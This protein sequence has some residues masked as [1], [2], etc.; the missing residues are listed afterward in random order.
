MKPT[1]EGSS[2]SCE[3]L[4]KHLLDLPISCIMKTNS[5]YRLTRNASVIQCIKLPSRKCENKISLKVWRRWGKNPRLAHRAK[6]SSQKT[7][8]SVCSY[9]YLQLNPI[10]GSIHFTLL[11]GRKKPQLCNRLKYLII[12]R[13]IHEVNIMWWNVLGISAAC[14]TEGAQGLFQQ[15]IHVQ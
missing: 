2:L 1:L 10:W 12:S 15:I 13:N 8:K 14:I 5:L 3:E 7:R 11:R 9:I 6:K 4:Q